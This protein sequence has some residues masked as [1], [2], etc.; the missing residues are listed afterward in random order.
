MRGDPGDRRPGSRSRGAIE[1]RSLPTL[2]RCFPRSF[3][4]Y[5][6]FPI[7]SIR[8]H[9]WAPIETR[10]LPA[11][12]HVLPRMS[13][14][15]A[16]FVVAAWQRRLL[17]SRRRLGGRGLLRFP[18]SRAFGFRLLLCLLLIRFRRF[19][20]HDEKGSS[21]DPQSQRGL[22]RPRLLLGAGR[23]LIC[24]LSGFSLAKEEQVNEND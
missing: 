3:T 11:L 13:S 15:P 24:S 10:S 2:T 16:N 20:A 9:A 8:R 7:R 14:A 1:T 22:G 4:F 5:V 23:S 19:V 12:T 6:A 21:C 17:L 18:L